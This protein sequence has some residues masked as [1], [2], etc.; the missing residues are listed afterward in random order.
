MR[1]SGL[2]GPGHKKH[3][4]LTA[5]AQARPLQEAWKTPCSLQ[6]ALLAKPKPLFTQP[7]TQDALPPARESRALHNSMSVYSWFSFKPFVLKRKKRKIE[8]ER[9]GNLAPP[10]PF[11]SLRGGAKLPP[12]SA[13]PRD[14]RGLPAAGLPT[15]T[16]ALGL[17]KG[18][19]LWFLPDCARAAPGLALQVQEGQRTWAGHSSSPSSHP[20][21]RSATQPTWRSLCAPSPQVLP[22]QVAS[23]ETEARREEAVYGPPWGGLGQCLTRPPGGPGLGF[24]GSQREV[25]A[26]VGPEPGAGPGRNNEPLRRWWQPGCGPCELGPQ[27]G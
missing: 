13:R 1:H 19:L 8:K 17:W 16:A 14:P 9:K 23:G 22:P 18:G 10:P 7:D 24:W 11:P 5:V 12:S 6:P 2:P 21:W 26:W 3:S 27:A 25:G 20:A 15:A 4:G